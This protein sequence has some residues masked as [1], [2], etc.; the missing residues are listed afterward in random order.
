MKYVIGIDYGT[1]SA[2][3]VVVNTEN[4]KEAGSCAYP[5]PH[6]VLYEALP[7]GTKLGAQSAL[8]V[9]EDY[10]EALEITVKGALEQAQIRS[11]DVVGMCVDATSCT[12]V[13]VDREGKPLSLRPELKN[14]PHAYIKMWKHHAAMEQTS[15]VS[16][17]AK[18]MKMSFLEACGGEIS[19]EW[20]I[21]KLLEIR[22]NDPEV[23]ALIDRA[24][25]LC[26]F[27]TMLLT[28]TITRGVGAT[29]FKCCWMPDEGYPDKAFLERLGTGF[30]DEYYHMMEGP[31]ILPGQRAG[32]LC[33]EMAEKLNL[34]EGIAVAGG[35]LDGHTSIPT[36]GLCHAGDVSLVI[37]T[38]NVSAVM[39]DKPIEVPAGTSSAMN[40]FW[41]GLFA[42]DSGQSCTGDMLGWYMKNMLPVHVA[43]EAEKRGISV[44]NLMNELAEKAEPWRCGVTVLD[45]WNGN[46]N[47]MCNLN[48]QG[49]I[50]GIN[51]TTKPEHIYTG[52][53]QGIVCGTRK[54]LEACENNGAKIRNIVACGGIPQKNPFMMQQYANILNRPIHVACANEGPA[55]GSA[56]FAA[57]AAGVF[58][59]FEQAA[60]HMKV[61]EYIEYLPQ[62]E[63]Q[64][65]YEKIYQRFCRYYD[66]LGKSDQ[67]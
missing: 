61:H 27:L 44:F 46:R 55:M 34:P 8:A 48:L 37:G 29:A 32:G 23:Y 35:I 53:V 38:S 33:R 5:Y 22:E 63:H 43:A 57:C 4:G 56:I 17:L 51:L 49:N 13:P 26:D 67:F 62:Q 14:R 15:R 11:E 18:E 6:G 25:D 40:G 19:S 52:M 50:L 28:G 60:E 3:A 45:W 64:R 16:A 59:S 66:A 41:P 2:R 42:I 7:D 12:V 21:P 31:V 20:M 39:T 58:E 47:V 24:Y 30:G 54:I 65:E 1:Q 36:C 9:A 10:I